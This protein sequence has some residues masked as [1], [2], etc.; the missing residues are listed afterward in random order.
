L[1]IVKKSALWLLVIA[2]SAIAAEPRYD[3]VYYWATDVPPPKGVQI[4]GHPCGSIVLL[5]TDSVPPRDLPWLRAETIHEIDQSGQ[6]LRTWRVPV[7]HYPLGL[8]GDALLIAHGSS[9]I[10]VLR[11]TP[12]GKLE[13]SPELPLPES[14]ECPGPLADAFFCTRIP[15]KPSHL[16]AAHLICT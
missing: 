15:G 2:L 3:W 8:D 14:L 10:H 1:G 5:G 4:D 7:D 11:L 9:P 13:P 12:K 6:I 16:L